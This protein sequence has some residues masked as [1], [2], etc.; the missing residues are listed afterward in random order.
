MAQQLPDHRS[1]PGHGHGQNDPHLLRNRQALWAVAV[2]LA[3]AVFL[4]SPLPGPMVPLAIETFLTYAAVGGALF[5]MIRGDSWN[6]D[7]VTGWDQAAMLLV[8]GLAAGLFVDP[9]AVQAIL[10]QSRQR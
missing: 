9:D 6:A 5:A 8:V 7:H 2:V 3:V 1:G 10:E 4:A